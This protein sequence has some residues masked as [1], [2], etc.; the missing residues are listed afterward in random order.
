MPESSWVPNKH[1]HDWKSQKIDKS[2]EIVTIQSVDDVKLSLITHGPY[3][4]RA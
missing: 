1:F 2:Y 3:H 4:E